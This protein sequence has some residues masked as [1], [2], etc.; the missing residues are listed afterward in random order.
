MLIYIGELNKNI[1]DLY[2][3]LSDKNIIERNDDILLR[4]VNEELIIDI[5]EFYFN[6]KLFLLDNDEVYTKNYNTNMDYLIIKYS[7]LDDITMLAT[8]IQIIKEKNFKQIILSP[9]FED[10]FNKFST[11]S[12]KYIA[13]IVPTLK[14]TLALIDFYR[15]KNLS[16]IKEYINEDKKM[17]YLLICQL[18]TILFFKITENTFTFKD[19]VQVF[20]FILKVHDFVHIYLYNNKLFINII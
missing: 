14:N 1:C 5:D 18:A 9:S 16:I 20:N 7:Q 4:I 15:D 12:L 13:K 6:N 2:Y 17:N 3:T 10:N 8:F 11:S 19:R